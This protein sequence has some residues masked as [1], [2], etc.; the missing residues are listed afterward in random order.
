M[1]KN[2]KMID[3]RKN[4]GLPKTSFRLKDRSVSKNSQP[5]CLNEDLKVLSSS[6]AMQPSPSGASPQNKFNIS[7]VSPRR[8]SIQDESNLDIKNNALSLEATN[9]SVLV[10]LASP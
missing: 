9:E 8:K 6:F 10:E 7:V 5:Q 1:Y 2:L 3:S 4:Y